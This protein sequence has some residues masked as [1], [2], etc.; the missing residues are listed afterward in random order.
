MAASRILIIRLPCHKVFPT[1]P[2]YLASALNRGTPRPELKLLDLALVP[3]ARQ[4]DTLQATAA[5]FAPDVIAFSWRD[6]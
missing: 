3:R 2:L 5:G 1:G 6:M 4:R